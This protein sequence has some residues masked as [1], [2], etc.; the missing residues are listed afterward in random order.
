MEGGR[1]G[2]GRGAAGK[3][4]A[5]ALTQTR[6]LALG[7]GLA[8]PAGRIEGEV[9]SSPTPPSSSSRPPRQIPFHTLRNERMWSAPR[10]PAAVSSSLSTEPPLSPGVLLRTIRNARSPRH[11]IWNAGRRGHALRLETFC[12][13]A[14]SQARQRLPLWVPQEVCVRLRCLTL[15]KGASCKIWLD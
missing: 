2:G 7:P 10:C 15:R 1:E 14:C 3:Q 11:L 13:R 9:P 12:A 5:G 4:R 6:G 8:S